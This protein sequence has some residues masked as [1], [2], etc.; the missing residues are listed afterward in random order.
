MRSHGTVTHRPQESVRLLGLRL[1]G[2]F[3]ITNSV[4]KKGM[5]GAILNTLKAVADFQR[6]DKQKTSFI[7]A[8]ITDRIMAYPFTD[9]VRATLFDIMLGGASPKQV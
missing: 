3:L 6:G 4:E 2:A 5:G 1:I 8:L 7:Y 9:A